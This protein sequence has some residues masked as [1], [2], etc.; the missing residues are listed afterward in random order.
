VLGL[1]A[2]D[3]D[4]DP[5]VVATAHPSSVLRGPAENREQAF[6]ALTEDLRVAAR[7][8]RDE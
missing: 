4:I 7:L 2:T 1:P 5:A 3:L 8:M 6:A